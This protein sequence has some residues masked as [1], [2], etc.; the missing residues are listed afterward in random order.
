M[1]QA[2]MKNIGRAALFEEENYFALYNALDMSAA[3]N[4]HDYDTAERAV[5]G[6]IELRHNATYKGLEIEGV[7]ATTGYGPIMYLIAA[8]HAKRH[9]GLMASR[10]SG[11][12]SRAASAIWKNFYDGRG[13]ELV[14]VIETDMDHHK[15]PWLNIKIVPRKKINVS[16][17]IQKSNRVIGRDP[18]GE[19]KTFVWETIDSVLSNALNTIYR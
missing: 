3:L 1:K 15:E 7:F 10:V 9:G 2:T 8:Q 11:R 13:A 17:A 12:V 5:H 16:S 14:D 6:A 4:G 19:R 18:Y